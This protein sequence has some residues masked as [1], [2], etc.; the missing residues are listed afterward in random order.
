MATITLESFIP[1]TC[2]IAPEIPTAK[3]NYGATTLPVYPT[4]KS[5]DTYP[6]ST[7][8]LEAPIAVLPKVSANNSNIAKFSPFFNPLPPETTILAAVNSGLSLYTNY[9]D[10]NFAEFVLYYTSIF[11]SYTSSIFYIES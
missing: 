4:Y 8:A 6:A 5:F 11:N 7:A 2:Y 3:Y 10:I 9:S 1:A